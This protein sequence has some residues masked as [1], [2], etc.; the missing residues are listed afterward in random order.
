[1]FDAD[2]IHAEKQQIHE[3]DKTN[4]DDA[5]K[6][7]EKKEDKIFVRPRFVKVQNDEK[8]G[9]ELLQCSCLRI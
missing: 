8:L 3:T 1:M 9:Q 2:V 7:P 5:K 6:E 4:K